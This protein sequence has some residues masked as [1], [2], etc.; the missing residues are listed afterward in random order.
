MLGNYVKVT[1]R[2]IG[3]RKLY[4]F[5]NAFGL[6]IGIAFC[7]LIYLFIQD[8]QSFDQ[9]HVN[10]N[11]IFR[12]EEKSYNY[13]DN[14]KTE[15]ERY[16]QS[17][18]L[19]MALKQALKDELPEVEKA[20]RYSSSR[21]IVKYGDKVFTENIR[22]VDGD[23][24]GMFSF[25]LLA[26]NAN[27]LFK[28]KS[29]VVL[30]PKVVNK[31]FGTED[32]IGK[33]LI[34][35]E[36]GEKS[37]TVV[38]I[39]EAPPAN[40]SID[41]QILLPQ[42]NR[43]NY[44]RQM[45]RWG[46]FN[47]PTLVQLVENADL[48]NFKRN[49][50]ELTEKY[51]GKELENWRKEG[52]VSPGVKLFEYLYTPLPGW[53]LNNE[54][55]WEKVSDRKYSYIL[56]G[57]AILI[58]LIAC[59]NYISLALTTSAARRT[60]V[61]IRKVVGATRK[62]LISQFGFEAIVLALLS[63]LVG[64]GLVV[65]FLPT[66]NSFTEKSIVLLSAQIIQLAAVG[67]TLSIIVGILA[68]CYPALFLSGFWPALVLKS[69]FTARI[70]AGFTRPLVVLQ[71]ALSAF[72]IIS[73]VIM[74]RQMRYITTKD[75]GFNQSQVL[76]VPTQTGW[77]EEGNKVVEQMRTRLLQERNIVSVAGTNISF[78]QGWS[79]YGYKIDGENKSAFVYSVDPYYV[80]T[81]NMQMVMGRNFDV[82]IPADSNAVIVN[83]ALVKDMKWNDPLNA[84]LNY[85]EDSTSLG[86]RVIGVVKDYHYR[87]LE[88]PIEP[89]FL[90]M[91]YKHSGSL[92]TMM[93]KMAPDNI[94]GAL[95][96]IEKSWKELYPDKPYD[97]TF[98]DQDVA[99]QYKS[100][101]RW[102]NIMGLATGFAILISCL[103]LFGLAGISA[104]N[105]TKEIGIRKVMGAR[106][107]NI[108]ILLNRQYVA[109]SLIA[110][111]LAIPF[112]WFVMDQWLSGFKF[113]I[114]MGWE[115]FALSVFAGL[116]VAL[117]TVSYHAIKAALV[118]PAETLKYE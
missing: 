34:I 114:D 53:H 45:N 89:L 103:G 3:K 43:P 42:E 57:I 51:M 15:S 49:L 63:M 115:L 60:E 75:L 44:E 71:F 18:Y 12:I 28:N 95:Q 59:I 19:Q 77:S 1:A 65:L 2:N 69:G 79:K 55:Q 7:M 26:G 101:Q 62:Q 14:S 29:E 13:W 90:C 84:Y 80:S 107:S 74:L 10:K 118:N 68:G 117:A 93:I 76:I 67:I 21:A 116:V 81:L 97:Y 9:F 56:G 109:L 78:N 4:S 40:S 111:A 39:I 61:G 102:M 24:F 8:E 46:N 100:Y 87:S 70:Q 113:R 41:F 72:L 98:L 33:T 25:K 30:T 85:T 23:F 52:K 83:E 27:K 66:F 38:G 94:T 54:V 86:A 104:V 106:L 37:L 50:D 110:F 5:I 6:S 108:F 58:L 73:S 91:D 17:A 36:N 82:N 96:A 16:S 88:A 11:R 20:T 92:T 64:F 35:N 48:V 105:R 47:T 32:P 112:S 31:Y 22:Y 99:K